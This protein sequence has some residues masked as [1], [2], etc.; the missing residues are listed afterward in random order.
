VTHYTIIGWLCLVD[1]NNR[2]WMPIRII[3]ATMYGLEDM[4]LLDR[5]LVLRC[6]YDYACALRL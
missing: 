2:Q 3:E 1:P 5:D 4:A 6:E